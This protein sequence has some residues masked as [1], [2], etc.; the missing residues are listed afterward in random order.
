MHLFFQILGF[1]C[2]LLY[3]FGA[4]I[5]ELVSTALTAFLTYKEPPPPKLLL[6]WNPASNIKAA[7]E[8]L[9]RNCAVNRCIF[10][11]NRTLIE[12]ADAV[13]FDGKETQ[14]LPPKN[15]GQV[16][17]F[18]TMEAP[19]YNH[20]YISHWRNVFNWTFSYRRDS[21]ILAMYGGM[22]PKVKNIKNTYLNTLLQHK[23]KNITWMVSH[24]KNYN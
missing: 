8:R 20:R 23:S 19:V 7:S 24:C 3:A 21:D 18:S 14:Y 11:D 6:Y 22:T 13:I 17:I 1:L 9:F 2:I 4:S 15:I 5:L 16:W 12:Q 10:S